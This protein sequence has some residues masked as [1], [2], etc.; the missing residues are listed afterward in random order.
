M[1]A[2][3]DWI[4]KRLYIGLEGGR[5]A[6]SGELIEVSDRGAVFAYTED[7]DA[8]LRNAF[9]PWR[10]VRFLDLDPSESE[11]QQSPEAEGGTGMME[12]VS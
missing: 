9:Y 7:N 12:R 5:E 6:I 4:G 1:A 3:E 8:S 11:S 2:P 10:I